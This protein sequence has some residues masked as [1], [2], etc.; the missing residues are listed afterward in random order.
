[1]KLKSITQ[2]SKTRQPNIVQ[3]ND[4]LIWYLHAE[5]SQQENVKESLFSVT[6][7]F[8]SSKSRILPL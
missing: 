6:E 3:L 8:W 2:I 5:E 7:Q 1:M 4:L